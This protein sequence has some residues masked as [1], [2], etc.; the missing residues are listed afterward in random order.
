VLSALSEPALDDTILFARD[1]EQGGTIVRRLGELPHF[2]DV[3]D[4]TGIDELF[5]TGWLEFAV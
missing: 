4:K 2:D 5:S 1:D 3:K